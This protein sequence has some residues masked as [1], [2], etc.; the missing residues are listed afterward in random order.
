MPLASWHPDASHSVAEVIVVFE[1]RVTK[2]D[3]VYR[4]REG[5]YMRDE[6]TS[7]GD[8]GRAF[9]SS[10]L[11]ESEY[12]RVEAAYVTAAVAF[13]REAGVLS[14]AVAGLEN[15]APSR[16]HSPRDRHSA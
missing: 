2:Y 15:H 14:L 6:W 7:V 8:I 4:D 16:C 13:L 12:R 11:T 3:P 10:V 9:G 1:F 5:V